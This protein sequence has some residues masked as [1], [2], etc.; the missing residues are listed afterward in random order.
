MGRFFLGIGLDRGNGFAA[1]HQPGILDELRHLDELRLDSHNQSVIMLSHDWLRSPAT[2]GGRAEGATMWGK[3]RETGTSV[4]S[5]GRTCCADY[6]R[7][8]FTLTFP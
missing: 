7:I 5:V 2:G 3:H 8:G 1:R 4:T 6:S